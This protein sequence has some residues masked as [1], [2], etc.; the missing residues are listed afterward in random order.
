MGA[1]LRGLGVEGS[2]EKA[3]IAIDVRVVDAHTGAVLDAVDV[4]RPVTQG[5]VGVSGIG[6][7]VQSF[8]HTDLQGAGLLIHKAHKE[9]VDRA[10]HECIE[11][12]VYQLA[13]RFSN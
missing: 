10:L 6:S 11:E 3:V 5:G 9:G 1:T 2:S 12:A 8:T 4:R 7:F 13:K